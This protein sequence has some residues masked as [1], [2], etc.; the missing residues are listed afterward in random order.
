MLQKKA[1]G[2]Y[3]ATRKYDLLTI[4]GTFALSQDR[5]LQRQTL[6]LICLITA[7]YNWQ[8]DLL[9]VGQTDMARLWSVD[10]RT[11]KR[12]M[13]VFRSRG[14]LVEKRAAARNR[15]AVYGLGIDK[16]LADTRQTWEKVGP[17]LVERLAPEDIAPPPQVNIIPFPQVAPDQD[18]TLWGEVARL[19]HA[20]DPAV[21]R[22]W[23]GGLRAAEQGECLTLTAPGAFHANYIKTHMMRRIERVVER[24]APGVMVRIE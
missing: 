2:R 16:I 5:A 4:L 8:A 7:R 23:F 9:T 22:A 1:T 19:L 24:L 15:V 3:G 12:E 14:W 20:E 6:R 13:A 10:P 11:V 18:G 21:F 17:D